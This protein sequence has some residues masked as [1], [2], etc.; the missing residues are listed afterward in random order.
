MVSW[1]GH[2]LPVVVTILTWFL[3]TGLVAWLD[4]RERRTFPR[5]LLLAGVAAIGGIVLVGWSMHHAT[6]TGAYLS[7]A[8]AILVWAWHEISFLTGIVTGPRRE[9]CPPGARG[10][11]RFSYAVAA[12]AWHEIGLALSA[13]GLI[14]LSHDAPN[15]VGAMAFTLLLVMRL[16]TKLAIFLGVPNLSTDILPP[17]LAY[18]K[19]YFGARRL[20]AELCLAI[21]G[22]LALAAWLGSIALAAPPGSAEA[23][24]ASL[25][26]ALATLGALEHLFLALPF[27]D[28]KLWGW[29]LP[30]R[31][32]SGA[33]PWAGHTDLGQ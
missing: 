3:A 29:A 32:P 18:L 12:M 17:Q 31:R 21:A 16:S 28:G 1:T 4:N 13:L 14:W 10:I 24:A 23:A 33:T 25:L 27:R 6:L 19:T 22:C 5:S 9:P 2:I 8:G 26:F 7:L 20:G 11:L 30:A 15:Q